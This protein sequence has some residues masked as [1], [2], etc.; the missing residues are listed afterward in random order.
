MKP[1]KN[2]LTKL[3]VAI[4]LVAGLGL[5]GPV[6]AAH[7]APPVTTSRSVIKIGT[8]SGLYAYSNCI[9]AQNAIAARSDARLYKKC[10]QVKSTTT[11]WQFQYY[12]L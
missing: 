2:S 12:M 6:A 1:T 9:G 5:A 11:T 8:F 4:A 10:Y 3:G 7:A